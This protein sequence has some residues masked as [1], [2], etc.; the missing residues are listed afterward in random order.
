MM[1]MKLFNNFILICLSYVFIVSCNHKQEEVP[2][3]EENLT[4]F[5]IKY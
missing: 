4:G 5:H 3:E 1:I 2:E